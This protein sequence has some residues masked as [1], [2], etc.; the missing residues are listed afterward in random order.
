MMMIQPMYIPFPNFNLNSS[1]PPPP[2]PE[3]EQPQQTN[4]LATNIANNTT[5]K[6]FSGTN[7]NNVFNTSKSVVETL[8]T[9]NGINANNWKKS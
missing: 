3:P 9:D 8:L 2:P 6:T 4:L 1:N 7:V 5:T